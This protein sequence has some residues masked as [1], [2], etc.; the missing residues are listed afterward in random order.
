MIFRYALED[1]NQRRLRTFAAR[2]RRSCEADCR[3]CIT[4]RA[5]SGE[6]VLLLRR[7]WNR[8]HIPDHRNEEK[9]DGLRSGNPLRDDELRWLAEPKLAKRVKAG[10]A[11]RS[12][13][14]EAWWA[15]QGSN[16]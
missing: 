10:C 16:L 2:L 5:S 1:T 3:A 6:A 4:A 15:R 8:G 14:G 7:P 12:P 11:M 9:A 13:K